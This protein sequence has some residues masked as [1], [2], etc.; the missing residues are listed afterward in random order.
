M[1]ALIDNDQALHGLEE[2]KSRMEESDVKH[3]FVVEGKATYSSAYNFFNNPKKNDV[4]ITGVT[5]Q[6]NHNPQFRVGDISFSDYEA[7]LDDIS[8]FADRWEKYGTFAPYNPFVTKRFPDCEGFKRELRE[9]SVEAS[10]NAWEEVPLTVVFKIKHDPTFLTDEGSITLN[11]CDGKFEICDF[12]YGPR[13][14]EKT[15]NAAQKILEEEN[16]DYEVSRYGKTEDLKLYEK[17]LRNPIRAFQ[18]NF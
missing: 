13:K 5:A 18:E 16:L 4:H 9:D 12:A 7:D 15:S 1:K 2:I 14:I 8:T 3:G 6:G 11:Y 17:I 10:L